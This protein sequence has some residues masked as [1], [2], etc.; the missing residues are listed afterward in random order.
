MHDD[1]Y[2]GDYFAWLRR[3]AAGLRGDPSIT[4]DLDQIAEE[5]EDFSKAEL[6]MA[7]GLVRN[8]MAGLVL[9]A[10]DPNV[11]DRQRVRCLEIKYLHG[12]LRGFGTLG[13][14]EFVDMDELWG[15]AIEIASVT[16]LERADQLPRRVAGS[17]PVAFQ[18]LLSEE[19][20]VDA[21]ALAVQRE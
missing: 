9:L 10:F 18:E 11:L 5:L 12:M 8:I 20:D 14:T 21:A 2:G 13:M 7:T 19:W 6:R 1:P 15:Q 3:Q 4:I 16:L 17:C